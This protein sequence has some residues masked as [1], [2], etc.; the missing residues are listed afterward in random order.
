MRR[1]NLRLESGEEIS[2]VYFSKH[3]SD[4]LLVCEVAYGDGGSGFVAR[5]EQ[6]S[7]RARWKQRVPA[8][9]IKALREGD[10][11][12]L[13]ARGFVGRLDLRKGAYLWKHGDLF[14][15]REGQAYFESFEVPEVAGDTVS[16]REAAV[17][18][19]PAKTIRVNRKTGKITGTE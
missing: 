8:Y 12:Y 6:P 16:F 7:M 15:T 13:A 17:S 19:R 18:Q 1:F 9:D 14:E 5:L 4:L 10:S 11:L 2:H 3:G